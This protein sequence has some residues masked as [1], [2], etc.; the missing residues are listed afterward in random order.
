MIFIQIPKF[1]DFY[2]S[3]CG[4][5]IADATV[6]V[7]SNGAI[8]TKKKRIIKSYKNGRG[9]YYVRLC[10]NGYGPSIKL[11]RL[12]AEAF[13]PNPKGYTEVNH[14]DGNKG[15]N[16]A[17]NLEWCSRSENIKHSFRTN[18]RSMRGENNS[19]A[20]LTYNDVLTIRTRRAAG[21]TY[22]H[23]WKDYPHVSLNTINN[24]SKF[25][26]SAK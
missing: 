8:L 14:K 10:R 2:V 12:V 6:T 11:H 3:E 19:N 25:W 1:P 13:V 20:K 7:R 15:N 23:I 24:T 4:T 18:L 22:T 17:Y 9:Y 26:K 5:V 16:N 21:E